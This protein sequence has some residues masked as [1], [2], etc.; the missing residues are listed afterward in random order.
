MSEVLDIHEQGV[1]IQSAAPLKVGSTL[2]LGLDLSETRTFIN[3]TGEVM[4]SGIGG[5]TGLRFPAM[6]APS[7]RQ[8]QE[9]L[10]L[11]ALAASAEQAA[12]SAQK[13]EV[14]G[15][16]PGPLALAVPAYEEAFPATPDYTT[17]LTA[18]AAVRREVEML[19]PNLA[20][21][22]QL[23]TERAR[24]FTGATGAAVALSDGENKEEMICRASSGPDAPPVGTRLQVGSGFSGECVRLG[25]LLR[26]DDAETDPRV[27]TK[28]CRELGIR[29]MIAV[30]VRIGDCAIGLLEV[31]SPSASAFG[32]ND[33]TVLQRL[34][35]TVLAAVNRAA[36]A[37]QSEA[38]PAV[39]TQP[40]P[41]LFATSAAPAPR[42]GKVSAFPFWWRLRSRLPS[43]QAILPLRTS[44]KG[45]VP[46]PQHSK[47]HSSSRMLNPQPW[48][49]PIHWKSCTNW[50]SKAIPHRSSQ[51]AFDMPRVKKWGRTT[52]RRSGGFR[53]LLSKAGSPPRRPWELTIG[54]AAVF[55]RT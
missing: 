13:Q 17:V 27:D 40:A 9:W 55:P 41:E 45:Q 51:W 14:P 21:A 20:K 48:L 5:R 42:M 12:Q 32:P 37:R 23:I 2:L 36:R 1:C 26:C 16:G 44:S 39:P 6:P 47:A 10:R 34:A 4:W 28:T 54:R 22:L 35:D 25:R 46:A 7:R 15:P 29:S 31:F 49:L 3:A 43:P 24:S 18:L 52:K 33:N 53:E 8:L 30:P 50:R 19:G 11:N 38:A